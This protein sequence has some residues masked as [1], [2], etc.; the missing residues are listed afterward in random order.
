[1]ILIKDKTTTC[2][3]A[4]V[5]NARIL[6]LVLK[7]NGAITRKPP[8][9]LTLPTAATLPAVRKIK[10]RSHIDANSAAT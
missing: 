5:S 9:P 4:G 2:Q 7:V 10:R 8:L 1:V 6:K 3:I